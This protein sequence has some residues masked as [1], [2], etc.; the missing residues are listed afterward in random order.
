MKLFTDI[1][2]QDDNNSYLK[3]LKFHRFCQERGVPQDQL[4]M[5]AFGF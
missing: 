4:K 1:F 2:D 5:L 3:I